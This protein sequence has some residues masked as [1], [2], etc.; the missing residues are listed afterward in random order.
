M[1]KFIL[2]ASWCCLC[3]CHLLT[4]LSLKVDYILM[5]SSLIWTLSS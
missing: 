2:G 5:L 3:R 4:K 1:P